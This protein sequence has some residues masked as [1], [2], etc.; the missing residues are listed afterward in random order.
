MVFKQLGQKK[1]RSSFVTEYNWVL[2]CMSCV[3]HKSNL[4]AKLE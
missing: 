2:Q 3:T 4:S 1:K